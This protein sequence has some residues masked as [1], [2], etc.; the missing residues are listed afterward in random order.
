M[1]INSLVA[2]EPPDALQLSVGG[3]KKRSSHPATHVPE[4]ANSRQNKGLHRLA[5]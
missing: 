1:L 3:Y 2:A 4:A 5:R